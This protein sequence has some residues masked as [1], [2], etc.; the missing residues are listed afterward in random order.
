[1]EDQPIK[2]PFCGRLG[3]VFAEQDEDGW[4]TVIC[5]VMDGGCSGAGPVMQTKKEAIDAWNKRA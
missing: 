5:D 1:M 3:S 2:C 4:W